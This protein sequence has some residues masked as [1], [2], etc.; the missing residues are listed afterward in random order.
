MGPGAFAPLPAM[1]P[2]ASSAGVVRTVGHPGN[3]AVAAPPPGVVNV[4]VDPRTNPSACAP[5]VIFPDVYVAHADN[6]APPVPIRLETNVMPLPIQAPVRVPRQ[7]TYKVRL[8]GRTAT[9]WPRRLIRWPTY[10]GGSA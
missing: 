3:L 9:S 10:G 6:M 7:A 1:I 8:G 2:S 4:G 5:N